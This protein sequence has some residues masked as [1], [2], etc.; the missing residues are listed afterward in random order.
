MSFGAHSRPEIDVIIPCFNG[1]EYIARAI[2]SALA[3]TYPYIHVYVVDDGSSDGT[4]RTVQSFG[5]RCHYI[6]QEHAG[7]ASARNAG[8]R[9]S[10]SPF[11]AFLDADDEWFPTKLERQIDILLN[12]AQVGLVC[13]A[14]DS[15]PP[16]TPQPFPIAPFGAFL[17]ERLLQDCFVFT[18]TV[19]AR[20]SLIEE[21]GLFHEGLRVSEDFN[22]WLRLASRSKIAAL[23][24]VLARRYR[25]HDSLSLTTSWADASK[26][27]VAAFQDVADRS[28]HLSPSDKT[29]LHN[30][31][32]TRRYDFGS[33]LLKA[34][35]FPGARTQF[36]AALV[37]QPANIRARLKYFV[38]LLPRPLIRTLVSA[39]TRLRPEPPIASGPRSVANNS[40]P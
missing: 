17:F 34:G 40:S 15:Q 5:H 12:D 29:A 37:S 21:L 33:L 35:D 23:P 30:A 10:H 18:P 36:A 13:C 11:L 39:T 24:E 19:L 9:T 16:S 22:L 7:V 4:H 2:D 27:G 25:R 6:R 28:P 1:E 14:C 20:R 26:D 38:T 8:I 31:L 3:Q 32:A